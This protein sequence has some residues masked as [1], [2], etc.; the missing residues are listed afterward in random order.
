MGFSIQLGKVE[1]LAPIVVLKIVDSLCFSCLVGAGRKRLRALAPNSE[2]MGAL[3]P[4]VAS[5]IFHKT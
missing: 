5:S 1:A 4:I 2:K 3:A